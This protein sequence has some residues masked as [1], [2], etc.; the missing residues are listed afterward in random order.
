MYFGRKCNG[1]KTELMKFEALVEDTAFRPL[2]GSNADV[3]GT[4][5][6]G[7]WLSSESPVLCC[8]PAGRVTDSG[9]RVLRY[10]NSAMMPT[11]K[12]SSQMT[13]HGH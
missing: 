1:S 10:A 6:Y 12:N 7:P 3:N 2:Y 13:A 5:I 4:G 8:H 9:S 11:G